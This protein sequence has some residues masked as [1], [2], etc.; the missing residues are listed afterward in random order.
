MFKKVVVIRCD[1]SSQFRWRCLRPST[2]SLPSGEH[3]AGIVVSDRPW[4]STNFTRSPGHEGLMVQLEGGF[5]WLDILWT[6]Y[7][8]A[9]CGRG[10][11]LEDPPDLLR[12]Q[13]LSS[14]ISSDI[15]LLLLPHCDHF[16]VESVG[17]R[18]LC[19]KKSPEA[20]EVS[21]H[22]TLTIRRARSTS[23][24]KATLFPLLSL[25]SWS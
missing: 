14:M 11:F 10:R 13:I 17:D 7:E 9:T 24:W 4:A 3:L 15:M 18:V 2:G 23:F 20:R 12:C 25:T 19:L 6:E 5:G 8:I 22:M 21:S 16:F 1:P